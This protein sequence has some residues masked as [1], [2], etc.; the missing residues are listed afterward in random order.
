MS[1]KPHF[2]KRSYEKELLDG[3]GQPFPAI[4][5]NMLELDL[6]NTW[7]GGHA[8]SIRGLSAFVHK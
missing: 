4:E 1:G 8:I 2:S 6:I 3:E 7:L 5:R